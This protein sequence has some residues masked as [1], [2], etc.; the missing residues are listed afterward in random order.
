MCGRLSDLD[1]HP[2]EL[3]VHDARRARA[4]GAR[5]VAW[6]EEIVDRHEGHRTGFAAC[7]NR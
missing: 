4:H 7:V 3:L 5:C 2:V 6:Y 1:L